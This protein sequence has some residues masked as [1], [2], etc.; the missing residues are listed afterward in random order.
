MKLKKTATL[1]L[2]L[3]ALSLF[4]FQHQAWRSAC[5][6]RSPSSHCPAKKYSRVT[7]CWP[8][9]SGSEGMD[10]DVGL[11]NDGAVDRYLSGKA[12]AGGEWWHQNGGVMVRGGRGG[13][14]SDDEWSLF[15]RGSK[16][17]RCARR[18]KSAGKPRAGVGGDAT[19][20]TSNSE[21]ESE[22]AVPLS[23]IEDRYKVEGSMHRTHPRCAQLT[24][25]DPLFPIAGSAVRKLRSR[26][27][28]GGG[29]SRLKKGRSRCG[30]GGNRVRGWEKTT[31]PRRKLACLSGSGGTSIT[32]VPFAAN[33]PECSSEGYMSSSDGSMLGGGSRGSGSGRRRYGDRGYGQAGRKR[34]ICRELTCT[35]RAH[36]GSP[37]WVP[38]HCVFHRRDWEVLLK[39]RLYLIVDS[40]GVTRRCSMFR[41][42]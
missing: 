28:L 20:T 3:C 30:S 16:R 21:S 13:D 33:S 22:S 40:I 10:S 35:R 38:A 9:G 14:G 36:Y 26:A 41:L 11:Y 27:S 12:V 39:V 25:N 5:N 15:G 19:S 4:Y 23:S 2:F 24:E 18:L 17:R 6:A 34:H 42:G 37:G 8:R 31:S 1:L 29:M 32:F 7:S